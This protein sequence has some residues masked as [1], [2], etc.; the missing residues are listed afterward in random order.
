[1]THI[2]RRDT[3]LGVPAATACGSSIFNS[4]KEQMGSMEDGLAHTPIRP[5]CEETL[6]SRPVET[7]TEGELPR[8]RYS[9]VPKLD[10]GVMTFFRNCVGRG[11]RQTVQCVYFG[12]KSDLAC[13]H[14][15]GCDRKE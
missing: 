9:S 11:P 14:C 3:Q 12:K 4:P 6:L 2:P 15:R 13:A 10:G 8:S 1:M 7:V 5:G